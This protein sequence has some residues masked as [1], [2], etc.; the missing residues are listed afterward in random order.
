MA[1]TAD[2][3]KRIERQLSGIDREIE[4]TD[5][6]LQPY[7]KMFRQHEKLLQSLDTNLYQSA[8]RTA[9]QAASQASPT[10][11]IAESIKNSVA[12]GSVAQLNSLYAAASRPFGVM[13]AQ[14]L[15][16]SAA[17]RHIGAFEGLTKH[18]AGLSGALASSIVSDMASARLRPLHA[19][20]A[21][22]VA[23]GFSREITTNVWRSLP[24]LSASDALSGYKKAT[25]LQWSAS[26]NLFR[27]EQTINERMLETWRQPSSRVA[28]TA[29]TGSGLALTKVAEALRKADFASGLSARST[30]AGPVIARPP[31]LTPE[32]D[33]PP[34]LL[35]PEHAPA[36]PDLVEHAAPELQGAWKAFEPVE[37][38][39][40][41]V[42]EGPMV[43]RLFYFHVGKAVFVVV[44]GSLGTVIGGT[45]VYFLWYH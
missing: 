35:T 40:N 24:T 17:T 33:S 39:L 34:E 9:V 41:R 25:A 29:A 7:Q 8:G 43:V 32:A 45:I 18:M 11:R 15:A 19:F 36:T 1:F 3:Y 30:V 2:T 10:M 31:I 6:L 42:N 27:K 37:V 23:A 4:R 38:W 13:M 21:N 26:V 28:L 16:T 44:T 22:A 12:L 14:Q 20:T 5:R